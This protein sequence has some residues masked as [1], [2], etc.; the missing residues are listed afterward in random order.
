MT[1]D[2]N[3]TEKQAWA[4]AQVLKRIGFSDY[5]Q[6]SYDDAEAYA[7]LTAGEA[8]REALAVNGYAPR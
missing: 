2:I 6:L 8:I 4:I 5:R 1:L 7:A 3:I